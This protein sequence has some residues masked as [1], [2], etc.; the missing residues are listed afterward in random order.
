MASLKN[1]TFPVTLTWLPFRVLWTCAR[2][3]SA[4]ADAPAPANLRF[5]SPAIRLRNGFQVGER[6]GRNSPRP[7]CTRV[8][9]AKTEALSSKQMADFFPERRI[10]L[11][12]NAKKNCLVRL[13]KAPRRTSRANPPPMIRK[14]LRGLEVF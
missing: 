2:R 14:S 10:V 13:Q 7:A 4:N 1:L 11:K 3:R 5:A 8:N 9:A 12:R 6:G